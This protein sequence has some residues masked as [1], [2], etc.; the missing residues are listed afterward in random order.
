[1]RKSFK[2]NDHSIVVEH[3]Y[4]TYR[5]LNSVSIKQR[6]MYTRGKQKPRIESFLALKD[7][8]FTV[9]KGDTV[10]I[11][12][13]NGAGKSTLLKT[14]A[15]VFQPDSG[16]IEI[17][18]DSVSLLTLGAGFEPDLSG[19]ENIYLNGVLLGFKRKQID[20]KIQEII[21]FAGIGDFIYKPL[22]TY[23][24][25]MRAR[26]AFAISS[27]IEPEILLLD[28]VLGVG[29]EEF[30]EKSQ[31][32]IRDLIKS[33]RTVVLVSHSMTTI[34]ELC[35]QVLWLEHGEV[36]GYG[37]TNELVEKYLENSRKKRAQKK[38]GS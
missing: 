32:K 26:L 4:L 27:N 17:F 28:E 38:N 5:L 2:M 35:D 12:G 19:I 11:I 25:G 1:M 13:S 36:M 10:G 24:S 15:G 3:V 7:V 29:D 16:K 22:R 34:R 18:S 30:R 31:N 21:D 23:S 33:Q 6:F 14:L 37:D 9:N 8:S 20:E